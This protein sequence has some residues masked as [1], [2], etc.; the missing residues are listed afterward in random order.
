FVYQGSGGGPDFPAVVVAV[1]TLDLFVGIA[2][3]GRIIGASTEEFRALQG[4]ARIRHAYLEMVPGVEPYFSA[5]TNDDAPSVL[6]IYGSAA[7]RPSLLLNVAHGITTL[8]G[9]LS[10]INAALAGA[11]VGT[12]V[13]ALGGDTRLALVLG[14]ATGVVTSLAAM[15]YGARAFNE[16]NLRLDVRF[17]PPP[18]Q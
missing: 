10:F 5:A 7:E 12:A 8:P 13:V 4:M 16:V 1:L 9:M 11:L 18:A 17:P 3:L 15:A 14:I 2:T 6:T